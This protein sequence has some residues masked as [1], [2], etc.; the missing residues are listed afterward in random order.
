IHQLRPVFDKPDSRTIPRAGNWLL[1]PNPAITR[2]GLVEDLACI[3]GTRM[4]DDEIAFLVSERHI[5]TPFARVLPIV[6][7][8]PWHEKR[9]KQRLR[10]LD[11]GAIDIRRRG[12]AGDVNA[13]TKRLRG[14]GSRRLVVAMTRVAGEPWAIICDIA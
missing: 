3:L 9:L 7:A 12:L 10:E 14:K 4:I 2:A 5:E 8:L 11:A 6:D 13:I 1:D